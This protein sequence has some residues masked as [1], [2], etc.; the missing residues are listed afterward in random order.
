MTFEQPGSALNYLEISMYSKK[1]LCIRK[2]ERVLISRKTTYVPTDLSVHV[3]SL[4]A[5]TFDVILCSFFE[6]YTNKH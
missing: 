5:G 2:L 4:E 3:L 1:P 6:N